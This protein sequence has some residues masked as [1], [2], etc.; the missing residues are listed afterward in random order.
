MTCSNPIITALTVE[1]FKEQFFR[2]FN[3]ID[4]WV[5]GTYNTGDEVFY[6]VNRKFYKCLNDGVS[7]LPTVTADWSQQTAGVKVSDLDISHAYAEACITFN[8]ALFDGD[9]LVLAYLYLSAHY[10]VNDLNAGGVEGSA[11]GLVNSRSVGNVSE[12]YSVPSRMLDNPIYGFY[13][14]SSYGSKYLNMLLPRLVGNIVAIEG[15]T[16]A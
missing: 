2:D 4:S 6:L 9:D 15:A 16:S 8:D 14:K 7:S 1:D 11:G 3:Y 13:A 10:L 5:A 12:G